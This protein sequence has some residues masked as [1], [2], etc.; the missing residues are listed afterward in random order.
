MAWLHW[1][2]G[3]MEWAQLSVGVLATLLVFANLRSA[4]K[5]QQIVTA[6]R[7]NG[8]RKSI[9]QSNLLREIQMCVVH[10]LLLMLS[11]DSLRIGLPQQAN[12]T[13]EAAIVYRRALLIVITAL[14]AWKSA[15]A[16]H[17]R[18]VL[19][20]MWEEEDHERREPEVGA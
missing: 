6:S 5:D 2:S 12:T 9:A 18:Y 20:Q 11:I 19:F 4:M 7:R 15:K 13:I 17:E 16:R 10:V 1:V 14:L 3:A 8:P